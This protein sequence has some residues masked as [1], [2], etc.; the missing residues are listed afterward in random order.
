V[1]LIFHRPVFPIGRWGGSSYE[2]STPTDAG[3]RIEI[4]LCGPSLN[5]KSDIVRI[6]LPPDSNCLLSVADHYMRSCNY[7]NRSSPANS[8]SGSGTTLMQW[9]ADDF[10]ARGDAAACHALERIAPSVILRI[11]MSVSRCR[12]PAVGRPDRG[13]THRPTYPSRILM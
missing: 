5:K 13:R 4:Y 11:V 1:I 7:I 6:Y 8:R 2:R 9:F 3:E 10:P 12:R